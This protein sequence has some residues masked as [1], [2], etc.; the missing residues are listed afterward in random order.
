M[1]DFPIIDAH[2]HIW[3]PRA[4]RI[5]W[6]AGNAAMRRVF[7]LADYA[8]DTGGIA[9]EA[10]V[11]VECFVD[12]GE[13]LNEV[14]HVERAA[15]AEPRLKAIVAQASLE[16]G[17]DVRPFLD[18]L[19]DRH[20]MVRGIRRMIEFQPDPDFALRPDFQKGV[21]MLRDYDFSFE[22]N[23]HHSQ[24]DRAASL[25]G[26]VE[27]VRLVLDHAGKPP[28]RDRLQE[29]WARHLRAFEANPDTWCKLSDLP[30]EADHAAWTEDDLRF[31]IDEVVEVFG[32]N[33]MIFAFDWP[34]CTQAVSPRRW[35]DLLDRHFAGVPEA[36]LRAFYAGNARRVY[37]L[38]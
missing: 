7:D 23:V 26:A 11:F 5:G 12:R 6:Q 36:D 1:P 33:R 37:R 3:D 15:R 27:G 30:V 28:I 22:V 8:E 13:F 38:G 10:M 20:P 31:Y 25:A 34:V 9:I 32:F 16:D 24:M 19:R 21:Q 2:L 14:R 18:H 4:I 29:P 35:I 17:E